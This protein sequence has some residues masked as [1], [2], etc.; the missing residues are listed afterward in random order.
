[1]RTKEFGEQRRPPPTDT[2]TSLKRKV[3][4][5]L[6]SRHINTTETTTLP[7][8]MS[9]NDQS[10][11]QQSVTTT[12]TERN[13]EKRIEG[14]RFPSASSI[15][16]ESTLSNISLARPPLST[17]SSLPHSAT[18]AEIALGLS[19]SYNLQQNQQQQQAMA[20]TARTR[21]L[22]W[23]TTA[24]GNRKQ[25]PVVENISEIKD[26]DMVETSQTLENFV[27]SSP[28]SST[29]MHD[30]SDQEASDLPRSM[31]GT[32]STVSTA[33]STDDASLGTDYKLDDT[34]LPL[35]HPGHR[36]NNSISSWGEEGLL[37][38]FSPLQNDQHSERGISWMQPSQNQQIDLSQRTWGGVQR[39]QPQQRVA[40]FRENPQTRPNNVW[41]HQPQRTPQH[42]QQGDQHLQ[43][44]QHHQGRPIGM[45]IQ[46]PQ[47]FP[48]I[49]P[50]Y[51]QQQPNQGRK[52][53][54]P[55][56]AI[57]VE[58][59]PPRGQR[60][61]R[62]QVQAPNSSHK[63]I[64]CQ[65]TASS[66]HQAA[67]SNPQRSSSEILKTLL[68]KKAC[69]FEP[70]TSRAVALVTWL[71]GR[72]LAME[73]GFFSRQQLQSGVHACVASK[74]DGGIITRTKVN[75]CMQI[76]L[77]SC[78][79]YIIPRSDGTEE[80]GDY[81]REGFSQSVKGDSFMLK[82]L[83]RLWNDVIVDRDTVL[84]ASL[85]DGEEKTLPNKPPYTP[86][87]SPKL[88]S[89][90][91]PRSP[92]EFVDSDHF[93]SKRAVLLCFN[94]NVRS[95]EDVFRCHNEFIRDTAN[96]A[97]LQLTAQEWRTFF[98]REAGHGLYLLGKV[99]IPMSAQD[100][101]GGPDLLGRMSSEEA[102]KFRT[103]WCTKRYDHDH[104]L[105]GFA[106]VEVNGGWL[107]RNPMVYPH[108]D[109]MCTFVS[110]ISDERLGDFFVNECPKGVHCTKA[111]SMEEITYHPNRYKHKVC[112]SVHSPSGVCP[113]GDVCPDLHPQDST[114]PPKKPA[115]KVF[116]SRYG[117]KGE[118]SV[119]LKAT[120]V[121]PMASPVVYASPAP[122]SS[123]E[124]QLLMPGLQSLY[125][126]H[127]SVIRAHV[128]SSGQHACHYS[129][130]GDDLGISSG[131]KETPNP[132]VGLPPAQSV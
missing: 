52:N 93:E 32:P 44:Y 112:S 27:L 74:I 29:P 46:Q 36:R 91:P 111:H 89:I 56:Q 80:K 78:F 37:P 105:C 16:H 41:S 73:Y 116:T 13:Q 119:G 86:K 51:H 38:G 63:T 106:H 72:E 130:F 125:R 10:C 118:Q 102:G 6:T 48:Q 53:F 19:S 22:N 75:R 39:S 4:T 76:I 110:K 33:P 55:S 97:H 120:T 92:K 128:G 1:M 54:N 122:F 7:L 8:S 68:R 62:T 71:V 49:V 17:P 59:T 129:C 115:E 132:S 70:D 57:P 83:S 31:I 18:A 66:P 30:T 88:S 123:F 113:M 58:P 84:Q 12:R 95:A 23:R 94:E 65:N 108:D 50:A 3:Q 64:Q 35:L 26:R 24:E 131:S 103:S 101:P 2:Q 87:S 60:G 11:Q 20:N 61:Q 117:K 21:I 124:K 45:E 96:A 14:E 109:E 90:D 34:L 104:R 47:S 107:R 82:Y 43:Y 100:A 114:R 9:V 15:T 25:E 67:P 85:H 81:F 121:P 98:G 126:R 77:N 42:F 127:S 69:L 79:H 28:G 40:T 99:G 5:S